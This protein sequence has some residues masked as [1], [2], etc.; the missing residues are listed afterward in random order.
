MI[1]IIADYSFVHVFPSL[2]KSASCPGLAE[3][4]FLGTPRTKK[5]AMMVACK[6]CRLAD[7]EKLKLKPQTCF[8]Y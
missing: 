2:L 5:S 6:W 1:L 4:V 3:R 8:S 7:K